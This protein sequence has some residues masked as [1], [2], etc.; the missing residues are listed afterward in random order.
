MDGSNLLLW[1]KRS[2]H[3]N[4][5][6]DIVTMSLNLAPNIFL[7]STINS[8]FYSPCLSTPPLTVVC[9]MY[10]KMAFQRNQQNST[11]SI[12]NKPTISS[13]FNEAWP[14]SQRKRICR[15]IP[16]KGLQRVVQQRVVG[17][18]AHVSGNRLQWKLL[19]K[20]QGSITIISLIACT[21]G[22]N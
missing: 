3:V 13:S 11:L 6:S 22:A 9:C 21:L 2:N 5:L 15:S 18:I 7:C 8:P 16:I 1:L 19:Y 14:I 12:T 10:D 4:H 17:Y 20:P